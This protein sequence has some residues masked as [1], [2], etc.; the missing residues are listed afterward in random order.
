MYEEQEREVKRLRIELAEAAGGVNGTVA[1]A[2]R[3]ARTRLRDALCDVPGGS[4]EVDDADA[5][6]D[7]ETDADASE[8]RSWSGDGERWNETRPRKPE[9]RASARREEEAGTLAVACE[10]ASEVR[11]LNP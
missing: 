6:A 1:S 10:R 3:R 9:A 8:T 7:A 2:V 4:D 5:D 11:D